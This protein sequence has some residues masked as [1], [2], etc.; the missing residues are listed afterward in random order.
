MWPDGRIV[1]S[2][3]T[4][5][6]GIPV[7]RSVSGSGHVRLTF[8]N[9]PLLKGQYWVAVYLFCENGIHVYD[10]TDT[11]AEVTVTQN[12]LE[13]GVVSLPHFWN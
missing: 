7:V 6:D 10:N 13:Q 5:F 3:S 1:C 9:L 2:A 12:T 8:P 4:F 11:A